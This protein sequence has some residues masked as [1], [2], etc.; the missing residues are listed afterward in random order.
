MEA[1]FLETGQHQEIRRV[2]A[3][4]F[5]D[6]RISNTWWCEHNRAAAPK[7]YAPPRRFEVRYVG[8][9]P[10]LNRPISPAIA[11]ID[12]GYLTLSP[13]SIPASVMS[14]RRSRPPI[15]AVPIGDVLAANIGDGPTVTHTDRSSA[16]E[17]V[18]GASAGL[19]AARF[20][21]RNDLVA[22][23]GARAGAQGAAYERTWNETIGRIALLMR[24]P[25]A[26]EGQCT[27]VLENL[28][29]DPKDQRKLADGARDVR[30]MWW[31]LQRERLDYGEAP[32]DS[33][34]A[35]VRARAEDDGLRSADEDDVEACDV[36]EVTSDA[37]NEL[38]IGGESIQQLERL[39]NL[40]DRGI[41]TPEELNALKKKLLEGV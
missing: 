27:V 5:D 2:R 3:F 26:K 35:V 4:E 1:T 24:C 29:R 25:R 32:L 16:G 37:E 34:D 6:D 10:G 8:G 41:I 30:Q 33:L 12:E 18:L 23:I 40:L 22:L 17:V 20:M 39:A 31:S 21:S 36:T 15:M 11:R 9:W 19:L 14:G 38:G 7:N 13:G 28:P